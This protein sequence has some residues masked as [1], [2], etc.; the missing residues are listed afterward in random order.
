LAFLAV[1]CGGRTDLGDEGVD[2]GVTEDGSPGLDVIG[3]PDSPI[4]IGDATIIDAGPP[5]DANTGTP[6]QCGTT[7]CDSNTQV[8]C[9]T[10]AGQMM[11]EMCTDPSSCN[12][13]S[14][15]CSSAANC[16]N[17]EVCCA[18]FNQMMASSQCQAKCMGGFQNPQ[19]CAKSSECPNGQTCRSTP[20]GYKVCRP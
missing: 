14:L 6:I 3:L 7:T 15:T 9:I 12:G 11:N 19:L 16:P 10:F 5:E 2:G 13:V 17:G 20:F 1:A 8:C 4:I 18:D